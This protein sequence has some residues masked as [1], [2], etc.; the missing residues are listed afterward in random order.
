MYVLNF[1]TSTFKM[2]LFIWIFQI[3]L[4]LIGLYRVPD[5][6]GS[7]GNFYLVTIF[8]LRIH[9]YQI[10]Y[11]YFRK[12]DLKKTKVLVKTTLSYVFPGMSSY[13]FSIIIYY[14]DWIILL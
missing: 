7:Y 8:W 5:I 2:I 9:W 10:H 11:L 3:W 4:K 13:V 14:Y 1:F 12:G 6:Q